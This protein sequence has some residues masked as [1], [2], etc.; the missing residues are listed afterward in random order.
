M[1]DYELD[2]HS[3]RLLFVDVNTIISKYLS[4]SFRTSYICL[5]AVF[6]LFYFGLILMFCVM[7]YAIARSYP[8]CFNS[9]GSMLGEGEG[10]HMFG[11][12]FQLSW[13]TF[14]TVV[15]SVLSCCV[16]ACKRVVCN[17]L[18]F[19][20]VHNISQLQSLL[21]YYFPRATE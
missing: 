11:D 20:L 4:W 8:Q 21:S 6:A 14:A 2:E 9:G 13:T 5:F 3:S 12:I 15:S 17:R 19:D 16:C 7:Y 1:K 10:A 18:T